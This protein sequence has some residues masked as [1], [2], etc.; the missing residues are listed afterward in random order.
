MQ[1][2]WLCKSCLASCMLVSLTE[3]GMQQDEWP[4]GQSDKLAGEA[5]PLQATPVPTLSASILRANGN[6]NSGLTMLIASGSSSIDGEIASAGF[7]R[8]AE[9]D[10]GDEGPPNTP[11]VQG[12]WAYSP[13]KLGPSDFELLRVVGQGAF[14]KASDP[15]IDNIELALWRVSPCVNANY[16]T[17]LCC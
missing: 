17:C 11:L 13:T 9:G 4:T 1:S 16:Q 7:G 2:H 15:L 14:G 8:A 12:E 10:L 3:C 6:G 5:I